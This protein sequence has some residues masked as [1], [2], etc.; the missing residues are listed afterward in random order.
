VKTATICLRMEN[1]CKVFPGVTALDNVNFELRKGEVHIL[2]GENG[3]GKSTLVKILSGAYRKSSGK[4]FLEDR[5]VELGDPAQSQKLGIGIIYQ[6]FNLIA[7][8]SVAE[9]IFLGRETIRKSGLIDR[10]KMISAAQKI[11]DELAVPIKA[12]SLIDTLGVAEQQMVEVAKALSLQA[13]ILIMDEPTS[14]LT[15]NEIKALFQTIN[16]LKKS[17]V[18][19]IYI[20]HRLEELFEIGDRVTVLRDGKYVATVNIA[21][22]AK[23]E[24]IRMMVDRDLKEQYPKQSAAIGEEVLRITNLNRHSLL[25]NINLTLRKGE[26]LGLAGLLGSGRTSL[27]RIIFGLDQPDSGDIYIRGKKQII[28]SPEKAIRLKIGFL[29]EDRKNQGLILNLSLKDNICLAAVRLF[30]R[31]GFVSLERE[32]QTALNYIKELHIRTT[33][34]DQKVVD[35]SGGNQQKVVVSK[36]LSSQAEI[37]IFDEPTRGIDVASKVEIYQIMNSLTAHGAAIMMISSDL[38]EILAMSDRIIVMHEG[39]LSAEYRA[40]EATQQKILHSAL[41]AA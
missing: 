15:E 35:L 4:I 16:N 9:N 1:I 21:D 19:V 2:L 11:L 32:K 18:S 14:A 30:S 26:V 3:A 34:I 29:T 41:G 22:T 27:A 6:E 40:E 5:E 24:L 10:K 12:T 39:R 7:Q 20:S 36:W 17:G 28:S 33:G 38:P 8:L 13:R 31:L 37:L 25:Q 23:S